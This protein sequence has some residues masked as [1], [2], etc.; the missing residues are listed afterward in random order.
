MADAHVVG[1]EIED[2]AELVLL[3]RRRQPREALFAAEFGI[4][5]VV[6]DDVVAVRRARPRLQERRGVEVADAE[7]F[8][9]GHE[10]G[11]VV[12]AEIL[13]ELQP[14]G[15][16]RHGGDHGAAPIAA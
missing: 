10:R 2:E 15:R 9:I 11:G 8:E 14:V 7:F 16:A 6:I 12:E 4:E 3:E 5:P 1:H 13:G